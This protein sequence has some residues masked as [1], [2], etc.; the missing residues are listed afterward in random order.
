MRR[1]TLLAGHDAVA[2]DEFWLFSMPRFKDQAVCI[3]HVEW[4][5]TSQVVVLLTQGHGKISGLAKG[6]RRMSPGSVARFSGGIELL[7]LGQVVGVI[8]P[9]TELATLTEWD[10]QDP[11]FH[12]RGNLTA[13]WTAMYAC[14]LTNAILADLDP[15]PAAFAGL[16]ALFGELA[17]PEA[18]AAALLCF[19]WLLLVECG[20]GPELDKDVYSGEPVP[21]ASTYIFDAR[22]GGIGIDMNARTTHDGAGPWRV[23]HETVHLLR[24][25][26][27]GRFKT[28][29]AAAVQRANR[30]LCVYA[31]AILDR[32]LPTMGF[33]LGQQ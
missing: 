10:L 24:Q 31:R 11:C 21:S 14:D 18:Y 22:G 16:S 27:A 30:L 26:A 2:A 23:R 17:H 6:S 3:R 8:K 1:R 32:Q 13:Q 28:G 9:S 12:L 5:E 25:V 7:T 19:Q 20:Y 33:V 15:H 4:S 29:P